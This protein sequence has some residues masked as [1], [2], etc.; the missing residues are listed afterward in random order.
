MKLL[1]SSHTAPTSFYT[2]RRG[3][4]VN[5]PASYSEGP[6]FKIRPRRLAMLIEVFRGFTQSLQAN[7]SLVP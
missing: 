4:V 3:W 6:S 1:I 7:S 5:T 2:E